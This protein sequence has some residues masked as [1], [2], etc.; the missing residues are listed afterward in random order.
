[1]EMDDLG[2]PLFLGNPIGISMGKTWRTIALFLADLPG[3]TQQPGNG[4]SAIRSQDQK[5]VSESAGRSSWKPSFS[6][7][8]VHED[9]IM[10]T[11]KQTNEQQED[12]E[13]SFG[14]TK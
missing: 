6:F 2:L 12:Q 8:D 3:W 9:N 11:S 13:K 10:A 7:G 14:E 5:M 4:R 1:M